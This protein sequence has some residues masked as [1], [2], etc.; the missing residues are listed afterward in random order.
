MLVFVDSINFFLFFLGLVKLAQVIEENLV[1]DPQVGV[2]N[3]L[4]VDYAEQRL[5]ALE[6][7]KSGAQRCGHRCA[8]EMDV[9]HI[10]KKGFVAEVFHMVDVFM[11]HVCVIDLMVTYQNGCNM[12]PP[13]LLDSFF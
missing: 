5:F 7:M 8:V 9:F 13:Q 3:V 11:P 10:K 2:A 6:L 1:G 12:S 4:L